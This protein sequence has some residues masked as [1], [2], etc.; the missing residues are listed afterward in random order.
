MAKQKPGFVRYKKYP[1]PGDRDPIL[2]Y[3]IGLQDRL[4][5]SNTAIAKAGGASASTLAAWR[6]KTRKPQF[7]TVA[8]SALVMGETSLPLITRSSRRK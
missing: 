3:V 4:K 1:M 6:T 2:D 8:A 7:A 5:L